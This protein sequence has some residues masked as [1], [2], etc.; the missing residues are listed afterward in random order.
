MITFTCWFVSVH[1]IIHSEVFLCYPFITGYDS[2]TSQV[3]DPQMHASSTAMPETY[4][5]SYF[6]QLSKEGFSP[7]PVKSKVGASSTSV[8]DNTRSATLVTGFDSS[9]ASHVQASRLTSQ[10]VAQPGQINTGTSPRTVSIPDTPTSAG[11]QNILNNQP[12][13]TVG[14]SGEF[15]VGQLQQEK[16]DMAVDYERQL[17]EMKEQLQTVTSERDELKQ[18]Q[19]RLNAHWESQVRRLEQQLQ[20][21]GAGE[22]PTGV[23]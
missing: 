8:P 6:R 21:S 14:S 23:S 16:Q 19:E 3:S 10:S 12:E 5:N 22:R 9:N 4:D 18:N 20:K 7:E 11:A 17:L 1:F 15:N 13:N 2:R